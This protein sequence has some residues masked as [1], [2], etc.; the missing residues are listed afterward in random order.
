VGG[1][2]ATEIGP[3]QRAPLDPLFHRIAHRQRL[4][5][6]NEGF[7]KGVKQ[8][9]FG[10]EKAFGADAT[11]TIVDEVTRRDTHLHGLREISILEHM[12][13][14]DPPSSSTTLL[15]TAPASAATA[16]PARTLPVTVAALTRGSAMTAAHAS[17][18]PWRLM[19]IRIRQWG[20]GS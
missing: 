10:D 6:F 18:W 1:Q 16:R 17:T 2:V 19:S 7:D 3:G 12:K 14:S 8:R 9:W 15:P 11:L 20:H 5:L 13:G 4:G